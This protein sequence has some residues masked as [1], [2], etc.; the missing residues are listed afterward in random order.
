M[1]PPARLRFFSLA[2]MLATSLFALSTVTARGQDDPFASDAVVVP[3]NPPLTESLITRF[4]NFQSWLLEIPFTQQQRERIRA[5]LLQ[6]WKKPQEIKN[7][8]TWLTMA[9][10]LAPLPPPDRE[11]AR[12]EI[13]PQILKDLRADKGNPDSHWLVEAYDDA[14]RPI[15]AGT[16]PLTESMAARFIAFH[17]WL[18]EVA[19]TPSLKER[20][21]TMLLEDWKKPKDRESD[22]ALLKWQT[23]LAHQTP[24]ERDYVRSLAQPDLIKKMRA[25][26]NNADAKMLVAAYDAARQPIAAGNPPL[27][28]QASDAWTELFCFI[29]NQSGGARMEATPA[30]KDDFAHALTENYAKYSPEKQ[31]SLSEMPQKL[32]LV[33]FLWLKGTDADRQ[34]IL[35]GWQPLVNPS[36]PADPQ[37]AAATEALARVEAF[38]AK[39]PNTVSEKEILSA[40]K[41]A[42]LVAVQYRRQG[43]KQDVVHAEGFEELSRTL[44]TGNKQAYVNL[45][46]QWKANGEMLA[47]MRAQ[48][49]AKS[50]M[51]NAAAIGNAY[52]TGDAAMANA[53]ANINPKHPCAIYAPPCTP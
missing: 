19:V 35:A 14:H 6:D 23:G 4:T 33:R 32:A 28:R 11:F 10:N 17:G 46:A 26:V 1:R 45:M 18:F 16:P 3:G 21:R 5:M 31:K 7:D 9:E 47:V 30:V 53:V 34:K 13:Q 42:D 40:A 44:H 51:R 15:V 39:D 27:T 38:K 36:Q 24:A 49:A 20:F 50:A 37:L 43:S 2:L 12:I 52:A 29:R 8:M 25:D 48:F 22:M 41:D